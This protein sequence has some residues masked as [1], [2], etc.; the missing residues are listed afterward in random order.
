MSIDSAVTDA[1]R[2]IERV[3]NILAQP[4]AEWERIAAETTPV[5]ALV[6]GYLLPLCIAVAV[7]SLFGG[8]LM[9]GFFLSTAMLVP[10]LAGAAVQVTALVVGV[11]LWGLAINALAPSFDSKRD[12]A[13]AF[14]L[15][16]YSATGVLVA[17]DRKSVV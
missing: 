10:M 7:A 13:R 16:A 2:L 9:T 5:P 6:A 3:K 11:L 4:T 12:R 14:R 1:P 15:S 8:L 17:R